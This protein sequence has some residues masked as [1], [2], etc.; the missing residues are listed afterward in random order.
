MH[1]VPVFDLTD[2]Q[3]VVQAG[4]GKL[5]PAGPQPP[6]QQP[7]RKFF[8]EVPVQPGVPSRQVVDQFSYLSVRRIGKNL[9]SPE[10]L[11]LPV[12]QVIPVCCY[13]GEVMPYFPWADFVRIKP[14]Q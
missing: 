6:D 4:C 2:S 3:P 12:M 7:Q 10:N 11:I 13:F 1:P 5:I 9:C 14:V 8:H